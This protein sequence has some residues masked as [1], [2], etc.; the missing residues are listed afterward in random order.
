MPQ[1]FS[2]KVE[3]PLLQVLASMGE[4]RGTGRYRPSYKKCPAEL[5]KLLSISEEKDLSISRRK[6]LTSIQPQ[7]V[8][9]YSSLKSSSFLRAE[10]RRTGFPT[11]VEVLTY[12]APK[13]RTGPR[14]I[15]S[16]RSLAKLKS[17]YVDALPM[18][19][20]SQT[21]RIHH[22]LTIK[23][24]TATRQAYLA[25]IHLQNIPD[26]HAGKEKK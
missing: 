18:L 8:A 17:T 21:G 10:K 14:E 16:Y 26:S 7:A 4:K 9:G 6:S 13:A 1:S 25:P 3:M 23:R 20:D 15:L 24:L 22:P 11:D 12:L 19:V 2:H 5:G